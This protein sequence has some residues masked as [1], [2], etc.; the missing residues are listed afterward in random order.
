M[1]PPHV[2]AVMLAYGPEPWLVDAARAVLASTGVDIELVLVDNG[3]TGDGVDVVKGLPGV[4][5]IRPE[6][7]T[8]YSG[9]NNLGAAEATGDWLAFVNSD[10]IVAPDALARVVEVAAEPGVGAA[11]ASIRLADDP[12]LINTSGNPLHFTGLSWAGGNGEPA[13]AHA[14]RTVVPSLSG[15]CFVISRPR[16]AELGGFPAEYFA[17]HEDTELSLRLWQR[18]LRLEYVPDAV[19][20]HHY[21]FSRNDLKLYLVERNRLL[22]LLTAYQ[23]RTLALLAPMLLLTE[24]AM[25]AAALAGGWARQKTRGWAW[26]W[27][28]RDWVRARRRR[29]QAERTVGDG[30]IADLMTARVA[31]SNVAAPP[32]TGVFNAV[33]AAWWAL[34]KPLLRQG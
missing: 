11:M 1:N 7:N 29:L 18:G 3:C 28:H 8:G 31:P 22:T 10:A 34:A 17:Y 27:R 15:C 6:E 21:E 9:G 25:F 4:R 13:S 19:V 14:R 12:D 16:W 24:A 23:G 26:L 33:A 32:G 5:V 20:R 2:T 30:V